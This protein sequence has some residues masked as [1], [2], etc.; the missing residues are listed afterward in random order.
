[1]YSAALKSFDFDELTS[2]ERFGDFRALLL[3]VFSGEYLESLTDIAEL[4]Q[5]LAP[6]KHDPHFVDIMLPHLLGAIDHSD[7]PAPHRW[8]MRFNLGCAL[9]LELLPNAGGML[10]RFD[11][12]DALVVQLGELQSSIFGAKVISFHQRTVESATALHPRAAKQWEKACAR[13]FDVVNE[14]PGAWISRKELGS[15]RVIWIDDP[16]TFIRRAVG[17]KFSLTL[18]KDPMRELP[19]LQLSRGLFDAL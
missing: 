19:T 10:C 12:G 1:M 2:P 6:F 13:S 16:M 3:D 17:L 18:P 15:R 11:T 4:A 5:L 7:S 8:L 9:E 14:A